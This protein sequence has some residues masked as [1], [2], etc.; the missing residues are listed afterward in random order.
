MTQNL[1]FKST[2]GLNT[3]AVADGYAIS[4][5]A[6]VNETALVIM[7]SF[8]ILEGDFREAYVALSNDGLE[9][10]L[11][12]FIA[13]YSEHRSIWSEPKIEAESML[14]AYRQRA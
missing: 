11:E 3:L 1:E 13:K 5:S 4:H 7:D 6:I 14:R 2:G 9:A 10:C 12:F 8:Y